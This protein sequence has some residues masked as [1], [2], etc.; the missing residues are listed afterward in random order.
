MRISFPN[1]RKLDLRLI[2]VFSIGMTVSILYAVL[3]PLSGD[4]IVWYQIGIY[5][6]QNP[7]GIFGLY[8]IP[9]Y[10]LAAFYGL[11][12]RLPVSHPNPY[13]IVTFPYWGGV[14]PYFQP[15]PE[16]IIFVFIMKL[17]VLISEGVIAVL[18][19]KLLND[20]GASRNRIYFA[21]SAWLLNPLPLVVANLNNVDI[22]ALMF[23]VLSVFLVERRRYGLASFALIAAGLMR[24]LA[25]IAL[26]FL[27]VKTLRARDWRGVL[28][29]SIPIAV[30]FIPILSYLTVVRPDAVALLQGRP[31]LYI[32]E[33][34]DIFGS[35]LQL[36]GTEYPENAIALTTLAYVVVLAMVTGR[37]SDS[38]LGGLVSAPILV[39]TA[40][41][42]VWPP[43]LIYGVG[44]ALVQ[45][46]RGKGYK[47]LTVLL[48][49]AGF[50][51]IVVQVG[52]Q[53]CLNQA[54]FLF[55]PFYDTTLQQLSNQCL[56]LNALVLNSGLSVPIRGMFSA[57][58]VMLIIRL[59]PHTRALSS[60]RR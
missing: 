49:V 14:P 12:L 5:V 59:I 16:A 26:P 32:P 4:W 20:S 10:V 24:M 54:S 41:S 37:S 40:F 46:A 6:Y 7:G 45:I 44:L 52:Q 58:I 42:W 34:L 21:V 18:I 22:L 27:I 25:F 19:Y 57:V 43:M 53:I 36:H 55:I 56:N 30:V 38:Q 29:T 35:V 9:P 15:T 13:Q 8:T 3:A 48:T 47:T 60:G 17:P 28:S 50:L 2:L 23:V 31:G 51:W 11:W 1:P 33:A 39:Y